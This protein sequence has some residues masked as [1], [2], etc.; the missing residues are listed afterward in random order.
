MCK[1]SVFSVVALVLT[2]ALSFGAQAQDSC[3]SAV[4]IFDG[5]TTGSNVGATSGPDPLG[6]CG[7]MGS[8]IWY[9]YT[10]TC[11]G[12]VTVSMCG[13]S[14]DTCIAAW[15]G[16]CGSLVQLICNDDFCGLQSQISFGGSLGTTYY[17]S[18]GG[19][20]G[21]TGNF[22]MQIGCSAPAANDGCSGAIL[23]SEGAT[24]TGSNTAATTGPEPVP[25]CG[26][27]PSNDLWYVIVPV[28]S[29]TYSAS[30]CSNNT[31]FD[32]VIGIWSGS[33][34]ALTPVSCNDDNCN[35][36]FLSSNATW[37]A[38]AG[39]PYYI[40]VCGYNGQVGSFDLVVNNGAGISLTFI[41]GG[42]GS[43]GYQVTGGPSSGFQLTAITLT[44]GNYPNDWFY[45]IAITLNDLANQINFGFPFVTGLGP[46]GDVT[47][48]PFFGLPS[49][50]ALYG[51]S[52]GVP[53]GGTYPTTVSPAATGTVP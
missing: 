31:T 10:A 23:I 8:D 9:T 45:G 39:V 33:C 35:T 42:P 28:C 30:T 25:A 41:N 29:G 12:V 32:T 47:V 40:S 6:N 14:Y 44:A 52:L 24:T 21:N 51:V 53:V 49:G 43:I 34:G 3:A 5:T 4:A 37:S 22:T 48:G 50:L 13:S 46:C 19:F 2:L 27:A 7:A 17:L 1:K 18:V 15:S 26:F 16:T 11:T 38:T 36:T 20:A